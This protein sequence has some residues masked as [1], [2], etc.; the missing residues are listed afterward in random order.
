MITDDPTRKANLLFSL[1]N[2]LPLEGYEASFK[3]MLHTFHNIRF[4][5]GVKTKNMSKNCFDNICSELKMPD[6][7]YR[8]CIE[9]ISDSNIVLFGFEEDGNHCVYKI[10]L[11]F[12]KKNRAMMHPKKSE[13]PVLQYLG[14][15]WDAFDNRKFLVTTYIWFPFISSAIMRD[16]IDRLYNKS[17]QIQLLLIKDLIQLGLSQTMDAF[18]P[19]IYLEASDMKSKRKSF[20][21]NLYKAGLTMGQIEPY[22]SKSMNFFEIDTRKWNIFFWKI[23]NKLLGHISGGYSSSGDSFLSVYYDVFSD[24]I[25]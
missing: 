1:L 10:Y 18:E 20:D 23:R 5:I 3:I 9:K 24:Q 25:A 2:E 17:D 6:T 11:E 19:Y 4:L 14:F 7:C 13:D 15:K 22:I 12:N 16:R 21:L 8:Q